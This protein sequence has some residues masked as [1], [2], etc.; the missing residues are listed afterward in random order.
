MTGQIGFALDGVLRKLTD[1]S[2]VNT[3]GLTLY[4]S[5]LGHG[6]IVILGDGFPRDHEEIDHFLKLQRVTGFVGIDVSVPSDGIDSVDRRLAQVA[7]MRRNGSISFM[8]EPD[9]RIAAR[10]L[11]AGLPTLLYLH[12]QYTV[13]SWR[14]DY[15][16]RL[17]RW[18]DLVTETDRQVSLRADE[19]LST[20]TEQEVSPWT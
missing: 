17:R 8:V 2:A 3:N 6:R 10:L 14:P 16:G 9:P 1:P 5:L 15:E 12:P 11:Q 19:D 18:D 4:H 7:R 20:P 13:P